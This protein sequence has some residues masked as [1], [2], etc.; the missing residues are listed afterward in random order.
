MLSEMKKQGEKHQGTRNRK[1][2]VERDYGTWESETETAR[3]EEE[4]RK[5]K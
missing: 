2:D 1:C 5:L 4:K 3:E